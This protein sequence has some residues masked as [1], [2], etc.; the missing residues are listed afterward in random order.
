MPGCIASRAPGSECRR[1][2]CHPSFDGEYFRYLAFRANDRDE[3]RR[4]VSS[5][6]DC[7]NHGRHD[8]SEY[9]TQG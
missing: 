5:E 4:K 2:G 7:C 3:A 6:K 1:E 9:E 8:N